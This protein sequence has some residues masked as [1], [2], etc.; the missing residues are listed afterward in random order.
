MS[1]KLYSLIL[2]LLCLTLI[3]IDAGGQPDITISI[4]NKT[5]YAIHVTYYREIERMAE[6]IAE[7]T[8]HPAHKET[9]SVPDDGRITFS[10]THSK[11]PED[12]PI[13]T[14]QSK[15]KKFAFVLFDLGSDGNFHIVRG[16]SA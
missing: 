14:T 15:I 13:N 11:D 4:E 16:C 6:T 8:V 10:N 2:S 5:A 7:I 12:Y 9:L 3:S 1:S